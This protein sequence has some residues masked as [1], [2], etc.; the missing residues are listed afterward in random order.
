MNR[1][2]SALISLACLLPFTASA[3]DAAIAQLF[4]RQGV[5]GTMVISSLKTGKT[6]VHQEIARRVGGRRYVHY[7]KR[8]HYGKLHQ[9]FGE[10]LFWLDGSLQISAVEQIRFLQKL[11]QR[12]LPFKAAS[13][14]TLRQIMLAEQAPTYSLWAKTGWATRINPQVGWYVGYVE[15]KGDTWLFALNLTI[16]DKEDLPKR[17]TLVMDAMKVKN[18]LE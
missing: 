6:F 18:L 3:E 16:N 15:T 9:P 12:T 13:Y 11:H 7:L 17:Q 4:A 10:T 2:K 5:V 1:L 14:D 8:L